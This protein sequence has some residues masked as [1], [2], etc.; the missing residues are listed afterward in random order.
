MPFLLLSSLL[1]TR[2]PHPL[3][4]DPPVPLRAIPENIIG[5]VHVYFY[6]A[7]DKSSSPSAASAA[8]RSRLVHL[9]SWRMSHLLTIY[10]RLRRYLYI[11]N[12]AHIIKG[13][14]VITPFGGYT[15]GWLKSILLRDG[16]D[17]FI[18]T[19]FQPKNVYLKRQPVASG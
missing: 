19:I 2:L 15:C 3:S 7:K 14:A 5:R 18:L 9:H 6:P 16:D 11:F 13:G 10:V 1:N 4:L 12:F 8:W 17:P